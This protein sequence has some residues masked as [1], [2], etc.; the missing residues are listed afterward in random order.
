[1][2]LSNQ[3]QEVSD[4]GGA[5]D[6]DLLADRAPLVVGPF[7][8]TPSGSNRFKKNDKAALY[9]QVY[10]PRLTEPNPPTVK[11]TYVVIDP[12]TGKPLE[13]ARAVDLTH[14]IAKGSPVIP[15]AF[16]LPLDKLQ[17]GEYLLEMQASEG[18]GDMTEIRAVKFVVQ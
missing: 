17:P 3:F 15:V 7:E 14:Y 9:A 16:Q 4:L 2:A 6:A 5:L 11:C 1:V 8:F 13:G 18:P 10:V 12:K